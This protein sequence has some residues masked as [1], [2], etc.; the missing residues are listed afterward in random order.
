[1]K[2][3]QKRRAIQM[4]NAIKTRGSTVSLDAVADLLNELLWEEAAPEQAAVVPDELP[5]KEMTAAFSKVFNV[6]KQRETFG[7]AVRAMLAAAPE[8]PAVQSDV[9]RDA[10]RYRWLLSLIHI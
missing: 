7:P 1:M 6:R 8:A 4:I 10:E 3:E 2:S 9:V 5:T